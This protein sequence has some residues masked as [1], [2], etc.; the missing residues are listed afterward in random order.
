MKGTHLVA[1]LGA[2]L[3][4]CLV[5]FLAARSDH[6]RLKL[7]VEG[8]AED[9]VIVPPE[10]QASSA[11][12]FEDLCMFSVQIAPEGRY[13]DETDVFTTTSVPIMG[14]ESTTS[15]KMHMESARTVQDLE[16]GGASVDTVVLS[17][18]FTT[19]M[20]GISLVECDSE[21]KNNDAAAESMCQPFFDMVGSSSHFVLDEH[22]YIEEATGVGAE[23]ALG[24][25]E[26]QQ[27][28]DKVS[29]SNTLVQTSRLLEFLPEHS[30][31]VN[32]TWDSSVDMGDF[33]AFEGTSK[34]VGFKDL[35]GHSC[36]VV[37]SS[38]ILTIDFSK[39]TSLLG[40]GM[41]ALFE[42]LHVRVADS[43]LNATVYW[44]EEHKISRL[45]ETGVTMTIVMDDP[46][47]SSTTT[48]IPI[49]ETIT[50]TTDLED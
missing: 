27:P 11:A 28:S 23:L 24:M 50:I 29:P 35:D 46:I 15:T 48:R 44:D 7:V 12:T 21:N 6:Q 25:Q 45:S 38:G 10:Q 16:D 26:Q 36:A 41:D 20:D 43:T 42:D 34:F 37:E 49:K 32:D 9:E 33:G 13:I 18:S 31:R 1:A 39:A 8:D 47:D 22:G 3:A 5:I 19:S 40:D 4:S 2:V 30:V 14:I 17:A